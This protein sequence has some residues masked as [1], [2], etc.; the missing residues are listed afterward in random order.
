MKSINSFSTLSEVN[1]N[2]IKYFYFD[3]NKLSKNFDFNLSSIPNSIKILLEN[4]I[5]KEDG[6]VITKKMIESIC[7]GFNKRKKLYEIAFFPS[8]V[9]MQDFTGFQLCR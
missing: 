1:I 8:R 4:L 6:E 9:L 5:R 7:R 2:N 3:L